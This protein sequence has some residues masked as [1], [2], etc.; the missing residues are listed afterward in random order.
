[1]RSPA[2]TSRSL[3]RFG[4]IFF[5][6]ALGGSACEPVPDT[7]A[8]IPRESD[9]IVVEAG[10]LE[11]WTAPPRSVANRATDPHAAAP[12][13]RG[14]GAPQRPVA[15]ARGAGA[16]GSGATWTAPDG[17][18]D[19][20]PA[21][22]MRVGQWAAGAGGGEVECALFHFPG[23]GGGIEANILRWIGQFEQPDG[24]PSTERAERSQAVVD[25]VDVSLVKVAGTFVTQDPPMTGPTVRLADHTLVAAIFDVA[26]APYFVK[27]T[28]PSAA[29][30]P[31]MAEIDEFVASFQFGDR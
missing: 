29:V 13:G 16:A 31:R 5:G 26:P 4:A 24:V 14:D 21:S 8:E 30:D 15:G 23:G 3:P 18:R 10:P 28:G 25:G 6:I 27:C 19:V 7:L 1:M 2:R 11:G 9:P 12:H 20:P 17:W 22:S